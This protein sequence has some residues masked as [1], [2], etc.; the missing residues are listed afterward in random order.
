MRERRPGVWELIVPLARDPLTGAKRYRSRTF[1]GTTREA[2]RALRGLCTDVDAGRFTGNEAT[3]SDLLD[4][5]LDLASEQ[6][7]PTTL[8]EYRRLI[9][10]RIQP[11]LGQVSIAKLTTP[12]LDAFYLALT[13]VAGLSPASVRQV[14]SILRR[15]LRQAVRWGWLSANPA[16]HASPPRLR[17]GEIDPPSLADLRKLLIAADAHDPGLG[18]LLRLAAATGMRRG[19]LCG[20]RWSNVDLGRARLVVRRAVVAVPDGTAEK[21]PK[22]HA[23]RRLSLDP[24]PSTRCEPTSITRGA[25]RAPAR[26]SSSQPPTSSATRST[27]RGRCTPTTSPRASVGSPAVTAL[28]AYG[29]MTCATR[30]PPN[31]CQLGCHC[32]PSAPGSATPTPLRRSTST[33]MSLREAMHRPPR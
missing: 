13:R 17:R 30:T 16:V 24:G 2:Q 11:A 6:L 33:R 14:H 28:S 21:D 20:L 9:A 3:V 31:C 18:V 26:S 29:C 4:R 23:V 7:S 32:E 25:T 1:R 15:S 27:A 5:W 22:T 12:Q 19:E 8:R 10:R